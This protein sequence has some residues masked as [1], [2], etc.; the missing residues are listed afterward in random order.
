MSYNL[1]ITP[2]KLFTNYVTRVV[3]SASLS[4]ISQN[5]KNR[6][7]WKRTCLVIKFTLLTLSLIGVN[8]SIHS[9]LHGKSPLRVISQPL[10]YI[11][12]IH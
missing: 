8:Y 5:A 11:K 12:I 7:S 4:I 1:R 9:K 6:E 2:C 10:L 3:I